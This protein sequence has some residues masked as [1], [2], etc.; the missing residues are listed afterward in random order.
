MKTGGF[1]VI[2]HKLES[3][4]WRRL[5]VKEERG[6]EVQGTQIYFIQPKNLKCNRNLIRVGE[7][8]WKF[9]GGKWYIVRGEYLVQD[10][11]CLRSKA[12]NP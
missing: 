12:F 9:E 6:S 1:A 10:D 11:S 5:R 3:F 4:N 7:G 8:D 2:N